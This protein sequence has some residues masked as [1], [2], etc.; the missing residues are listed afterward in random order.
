MYSE[1]IKKIRNVLGKTQKELSV[2]IDV[3]ERT[4]ASYE[5]GREPSVKFIAQMCRKFNINA[6]WLILDKGSMF[7]EQDKVPR[8]SDIDEEKI[9]QIFDKLLKERGLI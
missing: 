1:Q 3:P 9:R 8:Q 6:N 2:L 5:T 7:F 4:I